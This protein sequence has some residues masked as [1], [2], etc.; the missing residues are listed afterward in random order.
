MRTGGRRRAAVACLD[1]RRAADWRDMLCG[2]DFEIVASIDDAQAIPPMLRDRGPE[3]LLSDAVLPGGD[4]VSVARAVDGAA[5][6]LYPHLL[7]VPLAGMRLPGA[8]A[9]DD[10]GAMLVETPL[11]PEVILTAVDR[12]EMR[13]HRLSPDHE[14]RLDQLL[15]RLGVMDHP[16]RAML[17]NAVALAWRDR[18]R[19]QNLRDR[20]YPAA[21]RPLG[22]TGAQAERA[23]RHVIEAAWRTGEIDEQMRIFGDTIDARRGRPTCG[24]M[25][26]QLADILRW[27]G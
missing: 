26:A 4:A 19:L 10:L 21:A 6:N 17:K 23:I 7:F 15:I 5:L 2:A 8:A 14:N 3:L 27:E 22:K 16:G 11:S 24:E 13:S 18:R 9:L 25:I 12:L 20:V 1:R